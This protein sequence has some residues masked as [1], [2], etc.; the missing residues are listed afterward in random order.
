[1]ATNLNLDSDARRDVLVNSTVIAVVGMTDDPMIASYEVGTYLM[2]VGYTVYPVNPKLEKI[3]GNTVYPT[4]AHLPEKP[5]IVVVFR[6]PMYLQQHVEEAAQA[7]AHTVWG[8]LNI[9]DDDAVRRAL[10]LGLNIV[11]NMCIRAE[12]KRLFKGMVE[13]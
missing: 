12:H 6:K 8:Q 9:H 5:D 11:T 2:E 4:L 3:D 7:G 13:G 1:M 10:E